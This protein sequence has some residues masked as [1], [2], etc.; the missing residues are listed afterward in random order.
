MH[1]APPKKIPDCGPTA[2]QQKSIFGSSPLFSLCK[3][4]C[5]GRVQS[6]IYYLPQSC[7]MKHSLIWTLG[8]LVFAFFVPLSVASM[9]S[10]TIPKEMLTATARLSVS[11][12]SCS[13]TCGLGYKA[14]EVCDIGSD[15][16]RRSCTLRRSECLTNWICGVRH[17]T[18][19]VGK[20]VKL[21]CL[22]SEEIGSESPSFSYSW[23]LARGII[24]TDDALFVP[25]KAPSYVIELSAAE[26]YDAGTYRCDVQLMKN[27][28]LVKRIYFGLRVI[29]GNLVDLSFEKSLTEEQKL[30]AEKDKTQQNT[31]VVHFKWHH[32]SW[33]RRALVVFLVG[34]GSGVLGGVLLGTFFHSLLKNRSKS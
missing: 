3:D 28:K 34:I 8:T 4:I 16:K 30:E 11:S 9:E 26:E 32:Y 19:L 14:E 20:P 1:V 23:R 5:L 15:G 10:V 27:Y 21:R 18:V 25:F 6:F 33:Q 22:T 17:F 31:T 2:D 12:T 7:E 29:P 24:T 13:V